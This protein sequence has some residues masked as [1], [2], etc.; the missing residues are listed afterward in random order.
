MTVAGMR[1]G[2]IPALIS[3]LTAPTTSGLPTTSALHRDMFYGHKEEKKYRKTDRLLIRGGVLKHRN[4]YSIR[5]EYEFKNVDHLDIRTRNADSQKP[6]LKCG[7]LAHLLQLQHNT[8]YYI[9][10]KKYF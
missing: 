10:A 5:V 9:M 4:S 2:G 3:S 1:R 6:H 8:L 7:C